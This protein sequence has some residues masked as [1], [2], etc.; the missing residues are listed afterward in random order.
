MNYIKPT[1]SLEKFSFQP[2]LLETVSS[3][4]EDGPV[5]EGN[6]PTVNAQAAANAFKEVFNFE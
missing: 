1:L 5:I 4:P 2:Q 3:I 6:D